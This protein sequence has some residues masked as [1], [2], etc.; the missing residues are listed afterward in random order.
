VMS[1]GSITDEEMHANHWSMLGGI[2]YSN[3]LPNL[4]LTL[5]YIRNNPLVY[6]NDILTTQFNSNYYNMGHYLGDNAQEL[7]ASLD[8]RPWK[9]LM[10]KFWYYLAQKGPDYPYIREPDPVTGISQ[11]L[12]RPFMESV[13]WQQQLIGLKARYQ[14]IN[15]LF[16][17]AEFEIMD[18]EGGEQKYTSPFYHGSPTTFS[19]GVNMGF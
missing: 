15:D 12:G 18:T 2:R 7:Y 13:E 5:E 17:F 8:F 1:F 11:A 19:F 4:S 14:L 10:V 6:K 3:F 16:V 9:T